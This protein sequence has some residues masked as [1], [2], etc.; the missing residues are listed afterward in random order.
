MLRQLDL[1]ELVARDETDYVRIAT[2]LATDRAWRDDVTG[3][4]RKASA[5]LF[6]Q[7]APLGALQD[8]LDEIARGSRA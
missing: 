6:D 1:G 2:R 7:T 3:R 4:M 8:F 5:R